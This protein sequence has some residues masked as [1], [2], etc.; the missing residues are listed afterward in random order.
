MW[1]IEQLIM[2]KG[3][4]GVLLELPVVWIITVSVLLWHERRRQRLLASRE[5]EVV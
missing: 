2:L 4:Y 1:T 5:T 3:L